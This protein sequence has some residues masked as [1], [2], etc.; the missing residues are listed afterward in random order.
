MQWKESSIRERESGGQSLGTRRELKKSD[1]LTR[2]HSSITRS[3]SAISSFYGYL[4]LRYSTN[5]ALHLDV[6]SSE[7][8][9]VTRIATR[10]CLFN[11]FA[12]HSSFWSILGLLR[13]GAVSPS[14]PSRCV[15]SW[16]RQ[17]RLED[18]G[19]W[20]QDQAWHACPAR[21]QAASAVLPTFTFT[22]GGGR[23]PYGRVQAC[24]HW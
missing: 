8:A 2:A 23:C 22:Q 6:G 9:M 3:I 7:K 12:T 14:F 17:W 13:F 24:R 15:L 16:R 4:S 19:A 11:I 20:L 1:Q 5:C 21:L 18:V 10:S